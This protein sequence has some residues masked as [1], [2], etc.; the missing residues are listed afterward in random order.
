MALSATAD[1]PLCNGVLGEPALPCAAVAML[2]A[3]SR[4]DSQ[5]ALLRSGLVFAARIEDQCANPSAPSATP[6]ATTNPK[7]IHG[8][9]R[10]TA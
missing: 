9:V 6:A 1:C 2:P 8:N 5:S 10:R 4:I 7:M 3:A